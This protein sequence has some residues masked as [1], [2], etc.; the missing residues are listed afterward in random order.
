MCMYMHIYLYLYLYHILVYIYIYKYNL[1]S[2]LKRN[3]TAIRIPRP[4]STRG[5]NIQTK[6]NLLL[7][8]NV[9]RFG[10]LR[11]KV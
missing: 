1:P 3:N 10:G 2:P 11:V 6:R 7:G 4:C 8:L 9:L 5:P